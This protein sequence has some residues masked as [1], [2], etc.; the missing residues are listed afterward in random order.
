[1][2][3]TAWGSLST[4]CRPAAE[5]WITSTKA[6]W[7]LQWELLAGGPQRGPHVRGHSEEEWGGGQKGEESR[8]KGAGLGVLG[9]RTV[10]GG[11]RREE[12]ADP[13]AL[14]SVG[15]GEDSALT[16]E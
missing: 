12:G 8:F 4:G 11:C 5:S 9:S 6:T 7:N 13:G 2:S 14:G 16:P 10:G 15:H 1:M 3:L